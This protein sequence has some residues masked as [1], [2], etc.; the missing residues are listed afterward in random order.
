MANGTQTVDYDA[1]IAKHGGTAAPPAGDGSSSVDFDSLIAKHGGAVSS[2]SASNSDSYWNDLKDRYAL[3]RSV[4]LSK[5]LFENYGKLSTDDFNKIDV[6]K[7]SR[8]YAE[9]NPQA[10]TPTSFL[11]RSWDEVKNLFKGAF[12][13]S[14]LFG[15]PTKTSS[16]AGYTP[17][18]PA[19][20]AEAL[21]SRAREAEEHPTAAA[22]AAATDIAALS[23]PFLGKFGESVWSRVSP[24]KTVESALGRSLT[25][26]EADAP[27]AGGAIQPALANTPREVLQ[28]AHDEGINL[29][30]GQGTEDAMAQNLQ[31]AGTTAAVGGKDLAAA[32]AENRAKFGAAVNRFMDNVDPKRMGL[33]SEQAGE[34][35][36]R[37]AKTARSVAH[38]NAAQNYDKID[39]LMDSK[40]NGA[41]ISK[42]WNGIKGDLPIGA[43]DAILAQTPRSMR[44]VVEDLLSGKPEGFAPTV[45]QTIQLRKFF[46]DLGD[47]EGLPDKT[48]ATYQKMENSASSALDAHAAAKGA[49]DDWQA[50]NAGWKDYKQKYGDVKS[51]LYKI[52]NQRDPTKIVAQLSNAPATDIEL[53]K[54][55]GM[56]AALEPLKRQVIQDIARSRFRI[57]HD[58][59]GGYDDAYLKALFSPAEV[60]ELYL[61]ADLANRLQ[62]DPNPS[63]TGG[64]ASSISQLGFWNQAKMS[65]AAKLSM[66]RDALSYLPA[67]AVP[68]VRTT[69]FA[70]LPAS[71]AQQ[72]TSPV[73]GQRL[74][75]PDELFRR[76]NP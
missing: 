48:Q 68:A 20:A 17:P 25:A 14:A 74:A 13:E 23:L 11:G 67:R 7:F 46:R 65:A 16:V 51:P 29:T 39:Y 36:N 54:N 37:I 22:G 31:K 75:Q 66:P 10:A 44:A 19:S 64:A 2:A 72:V 55:E 15:D 71:L 61:K 12:G 27:R 70:A 56:T 69:P 43:E 33:S 32:L 57:A 62:Y 30:P 45:A 1:L 18:S 60:K 34:T 9:A 52:I 58:G 4:D 21:K 42:A 59:L 50:A 26:A 63:G 8:A 76:A 38:D 3:P 28:H 41:S 24:A 47:T 53:L 35:I 40:M 6:E 49:S 5:T 73:T